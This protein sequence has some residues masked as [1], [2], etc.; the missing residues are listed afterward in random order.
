MGRTLGPARVL[1]TVRAARGRLR[2]IAGR[3]AIHPARWDLAA[4]LLYAAVSLLLYSVDPASQ[5]PASDGQYSWV[6]ARSLAYDGDDLDFANDYALCGD[7][8]AIGWTTRT[9]HRA[10]IFYIG[11]AAFWT[12]VIWV[13]KHFVNGGPTVAGACVGPIPTLVLTMSSLAGAVL[14]FVTGAMILRRWVGSRTA[15]RWPPLLATLGG[16]VPS[17]SPP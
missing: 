5:R 13:L 11:P 16:H 1:R 17:T 15:T 12:P 4:A 10:N 3:I 8:F 6:Y 2:G 9:L 7:P 14:V